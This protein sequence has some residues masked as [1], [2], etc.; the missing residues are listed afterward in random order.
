MRSKLLYIIL[1]LVVACK[2]TE[3]AQNKTT[4]TPLSLHLTLGN[5]SNVTTDVSNSNNYL[6]ERPQYALS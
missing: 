2:E 5:T 4:D 3:V 1:L 6:I